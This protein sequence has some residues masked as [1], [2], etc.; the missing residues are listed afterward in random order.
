MRM[1]GESV[2]SS[3]LD[4]VKLANAVSTAVGVVTPDAISDITSVDEASF[5]RQLR[6]LAMSSIDI[7][8]TITTNASMV[9]CIVSICFV[10]PRLRL[11]WGV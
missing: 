3:W 1:T 5:A 4:A 7:T 8:F 10:G 11:C 2:S 9:R 6:S